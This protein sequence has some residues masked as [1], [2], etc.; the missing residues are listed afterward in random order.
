MMRFLFSLF[1]LCASSLH[2][3]GPV[4][5]AF[6]SQVVDWQRRGQTSGANVSYAFTHT[7]IVSSV[8]MGAIRSAGLYPGTVFRA[9]LFCGISYGGTNGAGDS[10]SLFYIGGP[11]LPLI[12]DVGAATDTCGAVQAHWKYTE[13]GTNGGLGAV[14]ISN[15]VWL[16]TGVIPNDVSSW[17]NDCHLAVYMIGGGAEV[18]APV[19]EFVSGSPSQFMQLTTSYT[20]LGQISV[21]GTASGY[22]VNADTTGTG[23]YVGTRTSSAAGGIQQYRNGVATG[24]SS[25]TAGSFAT[26]TSSILVFAQYNNTVGNPPASDFTAHLMG[27]YTMGRGLTSTQ[28]LQLY[29]AMQQAQ[30]ILQRQK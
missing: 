1:F 6:D 3:A 21:F 25:S 14:S 28:Q 26:L 9:N 24:T 30:T 19:G 29:N 4:R 5:C 27:G 23:F 2:A 16:T 17:I 8:F 20:G 15:P 13:T 7:M 22:P 11:Q 10:A 12:A 18:A